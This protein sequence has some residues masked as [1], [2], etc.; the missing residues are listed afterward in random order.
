MTWTSPY[1]WVTGVIVTASDLNTHLRDNMRYLKGLDG[2]ITFED[3]IIT[4]HL[5]DGVNIDNHHAR[6]E[7][8]GADA[9]ANPIHIDAMPDLTNGKYWKGNISNRPTET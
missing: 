7:S 1:T 3:D 5:V 6:H 2:G 9:L 8:G 4:S